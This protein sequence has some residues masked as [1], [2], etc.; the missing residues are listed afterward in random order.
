M[1]RY[2][3]TDGIRGRANEKFDANNGGLDANR[4]FQV[5]R[6]LG[7]YYSKEGRRRILIGKDTRLSSGMLENALAAGISA[8]GCD[9]YLAGFCPT[10]MIAYLT[11]NEDF[12]AG[13]MISASHNPFYDN[14][15]KI[16]SK[17]GIKLSADIEGLIEDYIDGKTEI[18]YKTAEQIGRVVAYPE[19]IEHYLGW[20]KK[21]FPLD[22][23]GVRLALDC[24]NGSSS[25]TAQRMLAGLGAQCHM[26]SNEPDG[27]NINTH[28]G[29]THPE[30]LQETVRSGKYDLGL[31]FD[32][33]ADR[34]IAV[35]PDGQLVD[36]DYVLYISGK[37]LRDCGELNGGSIVTT[38]MAN[39]GLFK[40]M[41][42][43]GIKVEST[44][45]GD[46][47]VYERMCE[48][49]FVVGGEQ[50]GH[51]IFKKHLTTG[52]GLLTALE[53]LSIM[54]KTGKGVMELREGLRIYPQLLINVKVSDKKKAM[55]DAEVLAAE[56]Q[57]NK[58][59]NGNGRILVRAS[60]TEPLVR[61]M[62]EAETDAICAEEVGKV[63]EIVKRKYGI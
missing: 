11:R 49:D 45:V 15:I 33:D 2:F 17:E 6:Y 32:G 54:Q 28:C 24:A 37:Y 23:T 29:S 58:D 47:Y 39:L 40:A 9:A 18:P 61:V 31:A 55:E 5:G 8:E 21:E 57:V 7:Y 10:P 60:G 36:G 56:E 52:D 46:K 14:G 3:G 26:Q 13:A 1:G 22:L 48:K 50:S 62:A 27:I 42:R 16:F 38:V 35:A 25:F 44:Q 53:L 4:A 12:A 51:I 43:E 63:V 59:L 34:L 19:G 20:L 30:A 41:E